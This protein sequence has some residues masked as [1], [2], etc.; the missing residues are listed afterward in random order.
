MS[1]HTLTAF[2]TAK[3]SDN[4]VHDD[5]VAGKLG[6]TGGLVPGVEV[7]AYMAHLPCARWGEAFLRGGRLAAKFIKPVFDGEDTRV[8]EHDGALSVATASTALCAVGETALSDRAALD[9]PAAP[10]CHPA[11]RPEASPDALPEGL[12]LGTMHELFVREECR[13]YL[14]AVSEQLP[15]FRD[16]GPA[17]PGFLLRRA[18]FVL[19]YSV[20]LGP[21]IHIASDVVFHSPLSDGEPFETR[22]QIT[23]NYEH[24]GH[25]VVDLNVAIL[26][27]DR[28]VMS[29]THSA[30]YRPRQLR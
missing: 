2:N 25:L 24:K 20:R 28:P 9:A 30:I 29:G 16:Q 8:T 22:G 26:S 23:R 5:E 15:L 6:F 11:E 17:H 18:N 12:V 13:W 1:T 10:R 14:D 4:K 27:S 3:F 7:F 21:W 19:A